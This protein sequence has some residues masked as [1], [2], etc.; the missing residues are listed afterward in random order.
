MLFLTI[1]GFVSINKERDVFFNRF[2]NHFC[3]DASII[4]LHNLQTGVTVLKETLNPKLLCSKVF[5]F[6]GTEDFT[7][8]EAAHPHRTRALTELCDHLDS[9]N[10]HKKFS[11]DFLD[12]VE[13]FPSKKKFSSPTNYVLSF[14]SE[15]VRFVTKSPVNLMA[16]ESAFKVR[17][18]NY[19]V[20]LEEIIP[21]FILNDKNEIGF[22]PFGEVTYQND[23]Y[24]LLNDYFNLFKY[25]LN[26]GFFF[27]PLTTLNFPKIVYVPIVQNSNS[28]MT[29]KKFE[30]LNFFL[31]GK[32]F[33][34]S[35]S[36]SDSPVT[37]LINNE[38]LYFS[39]NVM[40]VLLEKDDEWIYIKDEDFKKVTNEKKSEILW[41]SIDDFKVTMVIFIKIGSTVRGIP[42][43]QPDRGF[44]FRN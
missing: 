41:N 35:D 37:S 9:K 1:K 10:I 16:K 4:N 30:N 8:D 28:T 23:V 39:Y 44:Y 20:F 19:H 14:L 2:Q 38:N 42:A 26:R 33:T 11:E 21:F 32:N 24:D 7:N 29:I 3:E 31:G 27:T 12:F 17:M 15:M 5:S 13:V 18:Q 34:A 43:D 36:A 25:E 6:N 22:L 40:G